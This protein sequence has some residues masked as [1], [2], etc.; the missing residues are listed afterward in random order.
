[1]IQ[2]EAFTL[3]PPVIFPVEIRHINPGQMIRIAEQRVTVRHA[4]LKLPPGQMWHAAEFMYPLI[5]DQPPVQ[6]TLYLEGTV[7]RT[8]I[9]LTAIPG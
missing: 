1:M 4:M 9:W 8:Q 7:H 2:I 3:T 6:P 5:T